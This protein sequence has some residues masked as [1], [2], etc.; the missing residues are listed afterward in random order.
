MK[1]KTFW[2]GLWRVHGLVQFTGL[3]FTLEMLVHL[4][5]GRRGGDEHT[6]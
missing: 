6:L 5:V 4:C 2:V 1:Q 3:L